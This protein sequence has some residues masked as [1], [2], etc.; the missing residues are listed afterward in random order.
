MK[1]IMEIAN[2]IKE[3]GGKL[4]LVGGA[5]RDKIFNL[6][7]DDEDYC[8]VGID[9]KKFE[10][11]FPEAKIKGKAFPVYDIEGK[12]FALARAE[13]KNGKGHKEF[14]IEVSSK[15]TLEEDL[16]RRDL[17]INAIAEDVLTGEIIDPYNGIEDFKRKIIRAVSESFKEDPLRAYRAARFAAKFNFE[18]EENTLK[19]INELKSELSTLSA[20]RIFYELR[21]SLKTDHPEKFFEIL[22]QADILDVHFEELSKLIGAL[23]PV[24]YHPEGDSYNH[25]MLAL[26]MSASLTDNEIIRFCALVHDLGKGLTPKE[27]YPHHINHDKNGVELV[28]KLGNRLKLPN[29]WIKC[30]ITAAREHMKGGIF[31][32]MTPKK[33]IEFIERIDKSMLGL[34]GLE[35]VVESDRNCRGTEKTKV[36]FAELGAK[37]LNKIDGNYVMKKYPNLKQG[38]NLKEK[39]HEERIYYLKELINKKANI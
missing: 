23:Q 31:N 8:I 24:Q 9:A 18:V 32:K 39:M 26:K 17:T 14:L 27:E 22:R 34:R 11:L 1:K 25:T 5:V 13:Q 37:I 10:E 15:I 36:E 12:E 7:Q 2:I 30:G 35:I 3:N 38:I 29:S 28:K 19:M 4:Y 21:K 6:K 20:E 33:K 16:K